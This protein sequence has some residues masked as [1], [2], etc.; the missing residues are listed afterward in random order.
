VSSRTQARPSSGPPPIPW[1]FGVR[2]VG[3]VTGLTLLVIVDVHGVVFYV[4]WGL[5]GLALVTEA[6]ATFV[7]WR[8][9]RRRERS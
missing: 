6:A 9:L 3:V 2:A 8:D 7:Y 4:A 1:Q 5:I